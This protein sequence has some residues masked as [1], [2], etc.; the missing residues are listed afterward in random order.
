MTKKPANFRQQAAE[1]ILSRLQGDAIRHRSRHPGTQRRGTEYCYCVICKGEW[2][3]TDAPAH[4][5]LNGHECPVFQAY[6]HLE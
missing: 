6:Q 5:E 3:S 2:K 1:R 4:E